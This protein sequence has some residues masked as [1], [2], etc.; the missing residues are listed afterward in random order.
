M[1]YKSQKHQ[2]K[3]FRKVITFDGK[4]KKGRKEV[5]QS[6]RRKSKKSIRKEG[7]RKRRK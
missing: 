1:E 7:E 6:K 5:H 3:W 2:K 4:R